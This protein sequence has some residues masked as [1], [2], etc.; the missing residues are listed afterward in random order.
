MKEV[1]NSKNIKM[2]FG[3]ILLVAG[4]VYLYETN[5]V[6]TLS[7]IAY[8]KVIEDTPK[9]LSVM[10][11]N[12]SL[13]S[14]VDLIPNSTDASAM[15]K[16]TINLQKAIDEVSESGGGTVQLPAG[17]FYFSRGGIANHGN[18][19]Y[20]IRCRNNVHLKGAGTDE[21]SSNVTILKPYYNS[22]NADGGM[23]MFYF[24]NYSDISKSIDNI[25]PSTTSD[26]S[27]TNI[28][29]KK[30][31]LEDQT[32]YLINA[33]F[34]DFVIDGDSSRGG[35]K[36]C[37]GSY[38]TDGKGFMINLFKD[39]DFYN[40]VVKNTDATG[41]GVDCPINV[42]IKN[43]KA[44][45]CGKAALQTD[46][47]ASG[48]GIG[49]GYSNN[50]SIVI[51]N[52][53]ALN[54]KK[55]GFFFEHQA[56]FSGNKYPATTSTGFVVSNSVAGGNMY[57]FGGLKA[58]TVTYNNVKS[59]SHL[60]T[61]KVGSLKATNTNSGSCG[62]TPLKFKDGAVVLNKNVQPVFYT[63]YSYNVEMV[64]SI[65][66]S[67]LTDVTKYEQEVKWAVNN[68]IIPL[69]S[70]TTYNPN[71]IVTRFN[72]IQA[73]YSYTNRKGNV[74]TLKTTSERTANIEKVKSIGFTD[75][76]N[77]K[78]HDDLDA[79]MWGYNNK[80]LS[81]DTSFRPESPCTRGEIVTMLYRMAG[82]PSVSGSVPFN[83][84]SENHY[85]YKALIWGYKNGVIKG[86]TD[87]TFSPNESITKLQLAIF[88]YRFNS[89]KTNTYTIRYN[90]IEGTASNTTSYSSSELPFTLNNPKRSG[91]TFIGWTGSDITTPTKKVTLST[92]TTGNK[93]YTANWQ[94]NVAKISIE[95]MPN[96]V[97]YKVGDKIDTTGLVLKVIY[98][99]NNTKEIKTGYSISP[100]TLTTSGK[101]AITITYQNQKTTYTVNV[102][103]NSI[104]ITSISIKNKPDKTTYNVGEKLNTNGLV[105][106][107][108][109][110][111]GTVKTTSSG[112]DLSPTTLS[113]AG[114]Q[115][116]KV[117]YEGFTTTFTVNV[118]K[119]EV[120]SIS[121]YHE[122]LKL[123][124]YVN[125][126]I[127]PDGLTLKVLYSDGKTSYISNGYEISP[128]KA[129]EVGT[130]K[131]IVKYANKE[132]YYHINV[133]KENVT[134][135]RIATPATKQEYYVGDT[136]STK[137]LVL[138]VRYNN[139]KTEEI[140]DG[141]DVSPTT[142]TKSGTEKICIIYQGAS[143]CYNVKVK[144]LKI[145]E[146]S[147][148][149]YPKKTNYFV[150]DL[151]T[152]NGLVLTVRKNNNYIENITKGYTLS[153]KEDTKLTTAGTQ[154]ITV[155]YQGLKTSFNINVDQLKKDSLALATRPT[156]TNYVVG[157]RFTSEG[158][159]LTLIK[160]DGTKQTITKGF[161]L[162]IKDGTILNKEGTTNVTVTYANKKVT[163]PIVIKKVKKI[164]VHETARKI[165]Y[166][167]GD[168]FNYKSLQVSAEYSTGIKQMLDEGYTVVVEGGNNLKT[169]GNKTVTI[170][171]GDVSTSIN[172]YVQNR[173]RF[174][175]MYNDKLLT[176]ETKKTILIYSI[177][178]IVVI[179]SG[180]IIVK[181]KKVNKKSKNYY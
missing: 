31:V 61:Y 106:N 70:P 98:G 8:I 28:D 42:T 160:G 23:D 59:I 120:K 77:S 136:V 25:T 164:E 62:Y 167:V 80:I 76:A 133:K 104:N 75:I 147:I 22:S 82:S 172:I 155:T 19:D 44:I 88:L 139:G 68:G 157:D 92:G 137:G 29:G 114:S 158:L 112:Y 173:K 94:P 124:Y 174:S 45:N 115:T 33:D 148:K 119:V 122:P 105:L 47:G 132:T 40:V 5:N 166:F 138:H 1:F 125:D 27:Y 152:S 144:E 63:M 16:N 41:F 36:A 35:I 3:F 96:K 49:T 58:Y 93:V 153:M 131:V 108:H 53:I 99:D 26:I 145:E 83:D 170:S 171:Y 107:L 178:A 48:F 4:F 20:A 18:E 121:M 129:L 135:I 14:G 65:I 180:I 10:P 73:L 156:K 130:Q 39:S 159:S 146:I 69:T 17:T 175:D 102:K 128:T 143:I 111:D 103:E 37:N 74:T 141:F 56:R 52:C 81:K 101:Q 51:D 13:N 66:A 54:N 116:I 32:I 123:D 100:Q 67:N 169:T 109:Y 126:T 85:Y 78:Y 150:G 12:I 151:F 21:N 7:S 30:M 86:T 60:S 64:N 11:L 9:D 176:K 95:K 165:S 50:E 127:N 161:V 55:F 84:V 89:L 118:K 43:C 15:R 163:F 2:F 97:N 110:S 91:F 181:Y 177:I 113:T 90:L 140:K 162:S 117:Y 57:D 154:T 87:T 179:F 71:S 6:K 72:T 79:I 46:G 38:K 134:S 168:V 149:D 142:L 34:S 24:N